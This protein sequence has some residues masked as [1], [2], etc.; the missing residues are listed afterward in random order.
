MYRHFP[1]RKDK[2]CPSNTIKYFL[3]LRKNYIWFWF[4][5]YF[6]E[7]HREVLMNMFIMFP[8]HVK[9]SNYSHLMNQIFKILSES[10]NIKH[11]FFFLSE[12][13]ESDICKT[14]WLFSTLYIKYWNKLWNKGPKLF[15]YKPEETVH[16]INLKIYIFQCEERHPSSFRKKNEL[17]LKY[18]FFNAL[19]SKF[20]ISYI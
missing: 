15:Q 17:P 3:T 11:R 4:Q 14:V 6:N 2:F 13:L 10:L 16:N 5:F 20:K 19:T 8:F 9:L 7:A 1:H 12:K 18:I